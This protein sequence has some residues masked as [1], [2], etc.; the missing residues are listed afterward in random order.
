MICFWPGQF[1]LLNNWYLEEMSTFCIL[2][3]CDLEFNELMMAESDMISHRAVWPN[4]HITGPQHLGAYTLKS[5]T[6]EIFGK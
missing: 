6:N 5:K 1:E 2:D 3:R 4:D